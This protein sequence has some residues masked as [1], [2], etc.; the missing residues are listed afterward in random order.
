MKQKIALFSTDLLRATFLLWKV[1]KKI[2]VINMEL[3]CVQALLPIVSLYY[4]KLF[5]ETLDPGHRP[6]VFET[7]IPLI[8]IF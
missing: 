8:I 6:I 2:T 4:M 3:Q 7:I 5:L 1:D